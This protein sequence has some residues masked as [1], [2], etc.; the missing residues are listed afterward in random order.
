M[1]GYSSEGKSLEDIIKDM[2]VLADTQV[3]WLT[4]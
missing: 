3:E 1:G 2:R 4:P